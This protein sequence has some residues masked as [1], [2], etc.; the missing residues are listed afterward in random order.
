MKQFFIYIIASKK[1]G[2]LYV[3]STSDLPKRITE[4]KTGAIDGFTKKYGV[5][6]LVYF[7]E[8]GD[9]YA[10]VTRERQLKKWD[11]AWKMRLIEENNPEWAECDIGQ[12]G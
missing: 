12:G 2:T 6:T 4:H 7:E 1:N 8:F 9:A 3:G 11:R 5:K 10:M